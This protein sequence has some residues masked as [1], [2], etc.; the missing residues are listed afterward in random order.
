ME[1]NNKFRLNIL[2][3][4]IIVI[5]LA[6]AG[7]FYIGFFYPAPNILSGSS[8]RYL[9]LF[10][11]ILLPILILVS[12]LLYIIVRLKK[13]TLSSV[14]LLSI[15]S[16][17]FLLIAYPIAD[18]F[19]QNKSQ[20]YFR[21]FHAFL[22]RNPPIPDHVDTSKINIFC[23]GGSTTKFR[24]SNGEDWPGMVEKKLSESY[25]LKDIKTYNLGE[26]WYTSEHSL[27]NYITNLSIYKPKIIIIMEA[28]NDAWINV[29][30]SRF[31]KGEFR[32]DYGNHLG[33]AAYVVKFP[34][35]AS[36]IEDSFSLLWYANNIK[37]I[38]TDYF[39]G[40][41]SFERNLNT[42][43]E[44]IKA[45]GSTVVLMTQPYLYKESMSKQE[46]E[47]LVMLNQEAI[48]DGKKW[49]YKTALSA[50][51]QYNEKIREI[52][53]KQSVLLIDLEKVIPKSIDYFTDEVHYKDKSFGII[54]QYL[55]DNLAS[56]INKK[57]Q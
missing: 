3:I 28:I 13:V 15:T 46:L 44:L 36:Y 12:I 1:N 56:I 14:I 5:F 53:K 10:I 35:L 27:I 54:S 11:K 7:Y 34:S 55:A 48:G 43:I 37:E 9:I 38:K 8:V 24:D 45:N 30:F 32:S 40:L 25:K 26:A 57:N 4:I 41:N 21:D 52:A 39:P 23:L 33:P 42:L 49:S 16:V 20:R 51:N 47:I 22:Q 19:Y 6:L 29:D 50:M 31:S 17:I 18:Y 2:D